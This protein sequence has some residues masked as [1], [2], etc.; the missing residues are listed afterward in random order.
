[1][2]VGGPGPEDELGVAGE[3]VEHG[4]DSLEGGVAWVGGLGGA[5][6]D[7]VVGDK[8]GEGNEGEEDD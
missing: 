2:G 1:M 6:E 5:A 4:E 7:V 8:V 3:G